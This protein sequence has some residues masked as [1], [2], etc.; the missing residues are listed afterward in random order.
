MADNHDGTYSISYTL[1]VTGPHELALK[2]VGVRLPSGKR[3][4]WPGHPFAVALLCELS[5]AAPPH[6][7]SA[8]CLSTRLLACRSDSA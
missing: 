5:D 8:S 1:T 4:S 2:V 3:Q 7:S 6:P